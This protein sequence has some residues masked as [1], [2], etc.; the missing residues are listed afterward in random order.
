MALLKAKVLKDFELEGKPVKAGD[1]IVV[2]RK[3]SL[4][5]VEQGLIE[6]V[7]NPLDPRNEADRPLVEKWQAEHPTEEKITNQ[8][9]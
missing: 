8:E 3:A 1:D 5:L 9:E 4:E 2:Q 7:G 6:T